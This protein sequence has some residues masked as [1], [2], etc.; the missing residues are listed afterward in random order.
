[1]IA[2][3]ARQMRSDKM[4]WAQI[5]KALGVTPGHAANIASGRDEMRR[6]VSALRKF[7]T[8][9]NRIPTSPPSHIPA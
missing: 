8:T 1:M 5:G 2:D 6:Q 9:A 3:A 4:T 7:G